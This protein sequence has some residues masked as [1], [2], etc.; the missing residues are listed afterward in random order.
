MPLCEASWM[1]KEKTKLLSDC[2]STSARPNSD[3]RLGQQHY[4]VEPR[5]WPNISWKSTDHQFSTQTCYIVI[6][7][8]SLFRVESHYFF[9]TF[10]ANANF[11][12]NPENLV[13]VPQ[14]GPRI[15]GP[16]SEAP[17][18]CCPWHPPRLLS[19]AT[20]AQP[21]P[22][23]RSRPRGGASNLRR[24]PAFPGL[25][26]RCGFAEADD[27]ETTKV[28]DS[29]ALYPFNKRTMNVLD[30]T[31]SKCSKQNMITNSHKHTEQVSLH[32]VYNIA[33]DRTFCNILPSKNW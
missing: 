28:V 17:G 9:Q 11:F 24:F 32:V 22:G 31:T 1:S 18:H 14:D 13:E 29:W 27:V 7:D 12:L 19:R 3:K 33:F 8:S 21:S 23:P 6:I 10:A 2:L 15:S 4:N 16:A 25:F 26:G 5:I 30:S 20:T